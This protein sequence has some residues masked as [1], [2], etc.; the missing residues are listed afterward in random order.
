MTTHL[1]GANGHTYCGERAYPETVVVSVKDATCY[2]CRLR[3]LNWSIKVNRRA[4]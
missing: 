1:P 2:Y 3:H 4:S